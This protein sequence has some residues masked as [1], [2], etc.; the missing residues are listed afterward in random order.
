MGP[1]VEAA[2]AFVAADRQAGGD[3]DAR[4]SSQGVVAWTHGTRI[5]PDAGRVA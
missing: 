2:A 3:R 5:E 1:K 4:P